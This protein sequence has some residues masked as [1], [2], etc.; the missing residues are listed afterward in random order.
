MLRRVRLEGS[1]RIAMHATTPGT[2][3]DL[4]SRARCRN[5]CNQWPFFHLIRPKVKPVL[6]FTSPAQLALALHQAAPNQNPVLHLLRCVLFVKLPPR[7]GVTALRGATIVRQAGKH[8]VST[9]PAASCA[10]IRPSSNSWAEAPGITGDGRSFRCAP[11]LLLRLGREVAH[12]Q[13]TKAPCR[14]AERRSTYC[15]ACWPARPG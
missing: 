6:T 5:T 13:A 12:E 10:R 9:R 8:P 3:C 1:S 15:Q 7:S 11:L 14:S 4:V 2:R